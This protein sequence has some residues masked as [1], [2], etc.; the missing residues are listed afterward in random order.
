MNDG[1]DRGTG[2]MI[3]LP[4]PGLITAG[5]FG[6]TGW[7]WKC[8]SMDSIPSFLTAWRLYYIFNRTEKFISVEKSSSIQQTSSSCSP[9][10]CKVWD[11]TVKKRASTSALVI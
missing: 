9:T 7:F 5:V 6:R 11:V 8:E 2:R 4:F 10:L 3:R 1:A